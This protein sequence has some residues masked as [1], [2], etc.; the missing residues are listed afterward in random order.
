M[1]DLGAQAEANSSLFMNK[2]RDCPQV[3]RRE[4]PA[5][6]GGKIQAPPGGRISLLTTGLWL[7]TLLGRGH[8]LET[9]VS[10]YLGTDFEELRTNVTATAQ[11]A[12][13]QKQKPICTMG[14]LIG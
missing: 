11:E 1:D 2:W 7:Q 14:N 5:P 13:R 9:V 3:R 10:G 12:F 8:D 4:W 6:A